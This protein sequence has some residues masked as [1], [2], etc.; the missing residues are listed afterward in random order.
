[1]SENSP[2]MSEN[3]PKMSGVWFYGFMVN[4]IKLAAYVFMKKWLSLHYQYCRGWRF[5]M[6]KKTGLRFMVCV[7]LILC[8]YV[9]VE[10]LYLRLRGFV[11]SSGRSHV[12]T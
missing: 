9:R 4:H 1:M 11:T 5:C 8:P 7:A 6:V 3:S 2:K 10:V 12:H